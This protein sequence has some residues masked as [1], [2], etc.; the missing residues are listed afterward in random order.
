MASHGNFHWN[1]RLARDVD[2]VK[3]FYQDTIGW[4][5]TPMTMED[6]ATYWKERRAEAKEMVRVLPRGQYAEVAD[7]GH[8]IHYDRPEAW[9]AAIEPFLDSLDGE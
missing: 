9:L 4:S 8:L 2:H 1:E 7:A 5:Y 3:Q 6:G